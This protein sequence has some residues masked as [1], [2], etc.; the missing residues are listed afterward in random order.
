MTMQKFPGSR[1]WKFDFHTHT[2]VGSE[3]YEGS[4]ALDAQGW[5]KAYRAAGL[6]CVV[7][8]DHNSGA[9][10]DEVKTALAQLQSEDTAWDGFY[11]FPGVEISCSGG[12]HL[13]AVLDTDKTS[14]DIAALVGACGYLGRLGDSNAVTSKGFED[15][16]EVIHQQFNGIAI[17][18]HIDKKKGLLCQFSDEHTRL[19]F[20]GKVDAVQV[21]HPEEAVGLATGQESLKKLAS[22]A[23]VQGSDNHDAQALKPDCFTWVKLTTPDLQGL[24]LALAEPELSICRSDK[25]RDYPQAVPRHWIQALSLQG[26]DKRRSPLTI[27]FNPWLNTIIGGRGSGKSSVVE[28]LR[29]AL[30][31]GD[32]AKKMLT[33]DHEVSKAIGRF[34][35]G[36][37]RPTT[38]LK[39][40]VSGAGEMGGVYRYAWTPSGILVQR[41]DADSPGQ[42]TKTN[43]DG[44]AISREFPV[45]VFS[46]KQIHALANQP[47]GLLA[48]FDEPGKAH[49][50]THQ[51]AT[52]H[53][54]DQLTSDFKRSRA[55]LRQLREELK[56]WP[57][58]K[59]QLAQVEQSLAA[60]AKQGVSDTL[61]RLQKLRAE[62]RALTDF[63]TGLAHEVQQAAASVATSTLAEWQIRLPENASPEAAALAQTWHLERDALAS[64]W[65]AIAGQLKALQQRANALQAAPEFAAWEEHAAAIENHC[66]QALEQ[67][68]TQLGGQLL[69]VGVLQQQKEQ[70]EQRDKLHAAKNLRLQEE[71]ELEGNA[72]QDL[73]KARSR[74]TQARQAF[75]QSVVGDDG[76]ALL[77][78]TF[79]TAAQYDEKSKDALR[80]LLKLN[81]A[82]YASG[83][84]G[85]LDDEAST[86]III[87]LAK[88]PERLHEF[89]KALQDLVSKPLEPPRKIL[90]APVYGSRIQ[91]ALKSL[92]DEQL[93]SLWTWFPE[94][95][96]DIKF[97]IA[98]QDRWQDIADGSAGQQT[99]ALL[100]FI[101]NEGDEPLIL[102]QPEDDLDNAMVYDLV[103]QQLRQNKARRQV[104]VVTHNANIVVNGDAELVIPM[105]FRGGQIQADAADG[106]Q[107][108]KIRQIICNVMEGG[109]TA[110]GKRYKR[111]FKDMQ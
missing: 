77:K 42:W 75:V 111:I 64:Q 100:S 2:P 52:Q 20:L 102:D 105:A 76:Q 92:S 78:I 5:L 47:E 68:K 37:V 34:R 51:A 35:D 44:H 12:I 23:Q 83:F 72:Y 88:A 54:I 91:E 106:L 40:T 14:Q 67:V 36:M 32:E 63:Q 109:K 103:V 24:K 96:V 56:N 86:G 101:L 10:V 33:A 62:K 29:L 43:I 15:V 81:G 31:R 74:I 90:E 104:I 85:S 22:L 11:V 57:Q 49:N 55:R 66:L 97:R 41:P 70:L 94:D 98:A 46:Q 107:N 48:Y 38:E 3:D 17:A 13:I 80:G 59:D 58:V 8:T 18:A 65:Q 19:Q 27:D 25:S 79:Q 16:V 89:K 1:W 9:W 30:G 7:I 39:V 26:L 99:G 53:E 71:K 4:K 93:D 108:L 84:L 50:Q 87:A 21:V 82:D 60:Y 110:F 61:L 6:N 95:R 73:I 69:Q 45:R 28:C